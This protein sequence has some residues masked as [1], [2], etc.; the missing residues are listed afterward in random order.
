MHTL[1]HAP[2]VMAYALISAQTIALAEP[3]GTNLPDRER[4]AERWTQPATLKSTSPLGSDADGDGVP[5]TQD[6]CCQ[7]PLGVPVDAAGRP[8]GDCDRDCDVDQ[9]DFSVFRRA[10]TG[11]LEPCNREICDNF[12]DED[13]DGWVDCDDVDCEGDPACW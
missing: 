8:L 1:G 7:T 13:R 3:I 6:L 10:Y 9:A 4:F 2:F 5:D 12:I 11:P